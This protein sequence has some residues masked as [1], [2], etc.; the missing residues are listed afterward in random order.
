MD[1]G[2]FAAAVHGGESRQ[3]T[4]RNLQSGF[5]SST[6]TLKALPAFY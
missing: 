3:D 6:N 1:A 2:R 4:G 5:L